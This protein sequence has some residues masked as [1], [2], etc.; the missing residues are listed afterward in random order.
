MVI[1]NISIKKRVAVSKKKT[2]YSVRPRKVRKAIFYSI[3]FGSYGLT[4][5]IT[6]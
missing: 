2:A 4:G 1:K 6:K 3:L 5:K